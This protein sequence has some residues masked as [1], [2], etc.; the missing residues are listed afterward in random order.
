[1][2]EQAKKPKGKITQRKKSQTV[3]ERTQQSS[4]EKPRRLR[5]TAS[6]IGSPIKK[7]RQTGKREYHLP[8]PD[9]KAGRILGK[10]VNLVPKFFREA[11]GEIKLV[12]WPNRKETIRLTIAVFVFAII[13]AAIVG[14]LDFVLDKIF[15]R[16]LL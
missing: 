6:S 5:N 15:R 16:I 13:F 12:T 2:A 9:N 3:R 14:A 7:A 11:W 4:G 10:R 1:M 8:L